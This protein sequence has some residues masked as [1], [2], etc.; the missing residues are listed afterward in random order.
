[1]GKG[2]FS[3]EFKRDAVRQI[4]ER[5]Y[6]VSEVSQRLGV[7]A[8]SLYEWRKKYASDVSKGGDQADE[9]RQLKRELARVTEER[10]ILK[11]AAGVLRQGCKV[12][13]AFVAEHRQQFCVRTM[14]RCL[15]I[16][17]SGYYAWLKSPL[18]KRARED[19]RQ[20]ELIEEAWK[21]SGKVYG[22]RKLHDDL[23][24]QGE[25]SCANRVARLARLAGIKAQIGYRR[26][27]GAYGGKPSVVVDNTLARQFDVD[28][29]DTAW[30]TDITYIKTMEGFAYLAVVIDLFSRRV[31][32]WSLQS[33]QTSE[34]VLQALHMA[35][36]RRKPQNTV[37]VHSDQGSQFTSMDW[38]SFLRHHNLVHS[39]SRRGNCHDNAV[40][41]SFF[42]LLKRERIRRRTYRTRD[43]ARQ[44]VFDYIE[45]FYNPTRKHVR[46]GML[47]PVEFERRHQ[48]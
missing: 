27:P 25:T 1:M 15:S 47:S 7:S 11:K 45:M 28:A 29:P 5:G 6:P 13:Y 46:N 20:T 43:E 40:A 39:M 3:D 8:H 4:T 23:L 12:R 33:R 36:W 26:R 32:G 35:V 38:A 44:D 18:S 48:I 2:N 10:D 22:Y 9:I 42:N 19:I 37:L 16:H 14:C 17:P 24:D 31:V 21:Q 41:E 34:V 30:V